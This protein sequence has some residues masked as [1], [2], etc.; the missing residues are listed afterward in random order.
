MVNLAAIVEIQLWL[1]LT[2]ANRIIMII[3][4]INAYYHHV[5]LLLGGV[6]AIKIILTF[7]FNQ[8]ME[9]MNGI[10][11]S[12]FKWHGDQDQEMASSNLARFV[13]RITNILTIVI[14][15]LLGTVILM[16]IL[17]LFAPAT[18]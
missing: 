11:L 3:Q 18:T 9:G 15:V 10:I 5:W 17:P 6:A 13:F 7:I 1:L 4:Q 8:Q 12:I 14:Y 16:S 2:I